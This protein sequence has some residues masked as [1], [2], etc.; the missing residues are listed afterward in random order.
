MRRG[1]GSLFRDVPL[2]LGILTF[3]VGVGMDPSS[4]SF[5]QTAESGTSKFFANNEGADSG[6][7]GLITASGPTGMFLNL[8]RNLYQGDHFS[9]GVRINN[10]T[11]V[12]SSQQWARPVWLLHNGLLGYGVTDWLEVGGLMQRIFQQQC[13]SANCGSWGR[14][15]AGCG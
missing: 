6:G 5:A 3:I 14:L 9:S 2:G 1:M 4:S 12:Y 10:Q 11:H 13:R 7:R 15:C 8:R